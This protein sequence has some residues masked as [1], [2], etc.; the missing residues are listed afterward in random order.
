MGQNLSDRSV[1]CSADQLGFVQI[2]AA[3]PAGAEGNRC[4]KA[5]EQ[6]FHGVFTSFGHRYTYRLVKV[7]PGCGFDTGIDAVADSS[8]NR[9]KNMIH[10]TILSVHYRIWEFHPSIKQARITW[11]NARCSS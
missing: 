10:C 7:Q 8:G 4:G 3:D 5:M 9:F 6:I 2:A 1:S 11:N